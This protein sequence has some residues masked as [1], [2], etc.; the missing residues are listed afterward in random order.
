MCYNRS[1]GYGPHAGR[2]YGPWAHRGGWGGRHGRSFH[3][4][5]VNIEELDDRFEL[6]LYAPSLKKENF[7]ITTKDDVLT[8]SYKGEEGESGTERFTRREYSYDSFER[9]FQL[10]G[11]VDVSKIA[12]TYTEGVLT[13]ILPKDPEAN[14]PA[15]DVPVQ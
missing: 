14:K 2:G 13:V 8:V 6:R 4:V 5:P 15:Q 11:K 1:W 12:A 3:S 9:S 10:N 7:R